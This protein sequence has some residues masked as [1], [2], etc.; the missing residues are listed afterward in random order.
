[1]LEVLREFDHMSR[2]Y[3]SLQ[4]PRTLLLGLCRNWIGII[5]VL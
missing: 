4:F 3:S 5:F 1:M 2:I